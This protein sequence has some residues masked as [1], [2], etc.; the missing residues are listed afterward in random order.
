M[1]R[2]TIRQAK[3]KRV[4]TPARCA[5]QGDAPLSMHAYLRPMSED[6]YYER[7]RLGLEIR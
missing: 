3:L 2:R 4:R 5:W 7:A 1:T 6:D